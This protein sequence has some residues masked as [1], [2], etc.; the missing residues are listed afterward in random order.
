MRGLQ[1]QKKMK[2]VEENGG[3]WRRK[4]IKAPNR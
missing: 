1:I 4:G 3:K 2:V